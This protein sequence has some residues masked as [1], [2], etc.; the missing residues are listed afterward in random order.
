[1]ATEPPDPARLEA[2]WA[3]T[4][5]LFA[6]VQEDALTSQPIRLRQPLLFYVGHLPAFAWN[7]LGRGVLGNAAFEPDFDALFERGIDPE[8]EHD[9]GQ[10][11]PAMARIH[12][13]RDRVRDELRRV[14]PALS[15]ADGKDGRGPGAE[16]LWMVIEHELMHHATLLYMLAQ[17]PSGEVS[18]PAPADAPATAASPAWIPVPAGRVNLGVSHDDS[19]FAW[20]NEKPAAEVDV[21]AFRIQSSPVTNADFLTFVAD[22]GYRRQDAWRR[23]GWEWRQRQDLQGPVSWTGG[24]PTS[25]EGVSVL[26]GHV[27]FDVAATWPVRVSWAEADAFACW[28]RRR[29]PTEAELV[30]AREGASPSGA[31]LG[32]DGWHPLPAGSAAS[33]VSHFGLRDAWGNGWEWTSTVFGP[34]PGFRPHPA[35]P[36]YSADFFDGRHYVLLGGSWATD[37]QLARPSFRNWFQPHYPYVFSKFRCASDA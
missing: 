1:M 14:V 13:Y 20:D 23:A 18:A 34:L 27:P 30:R 33:D 31:H 11:W 12:A 19:R 24:D 8:E 15:D 16:R 5:Q 36:G 35:Y 32:F 26:G 2:A 22:G 17:M 10:G 6:M 9:P 4:D 21:A 7:Q 29:L 3:R 37:R 28:S 25:P